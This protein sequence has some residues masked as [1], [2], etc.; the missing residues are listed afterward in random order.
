MRPRPIISQNCWNDSNLKE[1]DPLLRP[2][3]HLTG[4]PV[5]KFT[6]YRL[7]EDDE[8]HPTD[9]VTLEEAKECH[10]DLMSGDS[11]NGK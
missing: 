3:N 1:R 9:V 5:K 10:D 6:V 11:N 8:F 2:F 7:K 4:E